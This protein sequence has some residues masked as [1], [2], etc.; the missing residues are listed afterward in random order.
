MSKIIKILPFFLILLAVACMGVFF[1]SKAE[2]EINKEPELITGRDDV[3]VLYP[4]T[5]NDLDI[6]EDG[7]VPVTDENASGMGALT[8]GTY[9]LTGQI[10]KSIEIDAHDETVH[11]I[12]D[13]A[14]IRTYDG[15][16]I[17]VRSAAK[18]VITAKEG[19]DNTL[20]DCAYRSEKE[21]VGAI[22]SRSDIT[23]NGTGKLTVS[24]YLKDAVCTSGFFKVLDTELHLKAKRCAINADDGMLL[25]PSVMIAESEKTGLKTG[26]HNKTEKGTVYIL[27]G[28]NTVI[29]G[30][31][32]VSSGR[33][34]YVCDCTLTI[35]AV[36]A[37]IYT[38]GRQYIM[39]GCL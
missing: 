28:N 15:P 25:E 32:A 6:S 29:A 4:V 30:N 22:Y 13:N 38:E 23:V 8:D 14:D 16:A 5:E 18:V 35:N 21:T 1:V 26:V 39:D 34:L 12:L 19:T 20:A 10:N 24:G 17:H 11:L 33:D 37:G 36:V 9:I 31:T 2:T 3:P 27:G 7:A